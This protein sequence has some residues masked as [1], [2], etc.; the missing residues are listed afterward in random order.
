MQLHLLRLNAMI[1][2]V[3]AFSNSVSLANIVMHFI[4]EQISGNL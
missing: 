2:F 4:I 1:L 3:L